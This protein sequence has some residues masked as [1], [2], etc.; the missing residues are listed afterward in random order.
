[1]KIEEIWLPGEWAEQGE[2]KGMDPDLFFPVR[3]ETGNEAK[4]VCRGCA[5]RKE[6]LEWALEIE[7]KEGVWGGTTEKERRV[8]RREIRR[9]MAIKVA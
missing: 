7:V 8:M 9:G 5:V 4:E 1:M 3:G 2:C 6:C